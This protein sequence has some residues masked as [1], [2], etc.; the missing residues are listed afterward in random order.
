MEAAT[1]PADPTGCHTAPS[2]VEEQVGDVVVGDLVVEVWSAVNT[3][4]HLP[5]FGL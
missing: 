2:S 5:L 1:A 3:W 4:A